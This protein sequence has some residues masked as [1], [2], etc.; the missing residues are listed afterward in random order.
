MKSYKE[1]NKQVD[2][3]NQAQEGRAKKG[4]SNAKNYT[5]RCTGLGLHK[6]FAALPEAEKE[7]VLRLN[8]L[9]NILSFILPN[10]GRNVWV[11]Y[12]D[13][14]DDL[15]QFNRFPWAPA[16]GAAPAIEPPAV[17]APTIGSSSSAT[18][19]GAVVVR[20]VVPREG[21]EVV[22]NLM[23]DDDV[24]VGRE[25]NFNAISSEYGIDLLEIEESKNGD[26]KV[27]DAEKDGEEKESE[28]EQP[29]VAE[30]GDSEPPT[31]VTMVVAEVAKTDIVFFNQ[32]EVVG[33]AYQVS[34]NQ[35][36][37]ASVEEQTLEVEKTK[38]EASQ[39]SAYQT[40][41]VYVEE[42]TLEV[43]KTEVVI[44]YQEEDVGEASHSIYLQT[45]ESKE[46]VEQNKEEVVEGKDDD[47]GN[48]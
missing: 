10:K 39:A 41:V 24:E 9:K 17:G 42:Q 36:T 21:L 2:E 25:V 30:E 45:K 16:I 8:L 5:S 26:E 22:N 29:Q 20:Q 27:D 4:T 33:E 46:E 38:N 23:V 35:T 3:E 40:T 19:I 1:V 31:V 37:A 15:Q 43:E 44:S 11:K 28:E 12:V 48:S 13:L 6:M 47:D 32:K 34:V 14:V 7:D 18:E